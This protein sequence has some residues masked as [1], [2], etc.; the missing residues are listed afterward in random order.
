[1]KAVLLS[2]LQGK[3]TKPP[4]IL[5]GYSFNLIASSVYLGIILLLPLL[6]LVL[7]G[8]KEG[9]GTLIYEALAPDAVAAYKITLYYSF[10]AALAVSLLGFILAW[11]LVRYDFPLKRVFDAL[12]DIPFALP[13]PVAGL[14]LSAIFSRKGWIGSLFDPLGIKL[15]YNETGIFLALLFSGLPFVVRAIQPVLESLDRSQEEAARLLGARPYQI[16]GRLLVP[17]I[18]PALLAGFTLA[19][20]RGLGEYGTLVFLSS[21][22]PYQTEVVTRIIYTRIEAH[23]LPG[24]AG[25]A[26][27]SLS[28]SLAFLFGLN[29]LQSRQRRSGRQ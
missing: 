1:M 27:F 26:L 22:I 14:A 3:F 29:L 5:P 10:L 4:R 21:N 15:V 28:A 19:F 6:A 17:S 24:A 25:I 13:G 11:T 8:I 23:N 16:F 9:L 7:Y 12:I 20:A 2:K 18:F